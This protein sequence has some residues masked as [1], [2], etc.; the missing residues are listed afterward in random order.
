MNN[1]RH[2]S[3]DGYVVSGICD[4][5]SV[6]PISHFVLVGGV[7]IHS[8]QTLKESRKSAHEK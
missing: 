1:E 4:T 5:V 6:S 8:R 2:L 7:S 3:Q